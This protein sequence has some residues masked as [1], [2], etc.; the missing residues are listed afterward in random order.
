M[1]TRNQSSV[2]KVHTF[3]AIN[4]LLLMGAIEQCQPC[5]GQFISSTF[6]VPKPNGKM[7]FILNLKNLNKFVD[8]KHFKIEDFR[9]ALKL[10]TKDCFMAKLDLKDAY[11]FVK[12]HPN[13]K[14]YLRFQWEGT[15]YQFCVLPFGLSTS[16]FVFTKIMKPVAKL[17]RTVGFL[18]TVYLDDWFI[19]APSYELCL[20]N[21]YKTKQLLRYLGF[22][23][24]DEKSIVIPSNSCI[25][26]GY[27]IDSKNL[28]V[29][30]PPDKVCRTKREIERFMSISRCKIREFARFVGLLV[31]AC[32]AIEYGWLYTK[33]FERIKYLNL[34]HNIN[35][36]D[37]YMSIPISIESDLKWWK[38]AISTSVNKIKHD[39]YDLE[40]FSDASTTGWG[41]ACAEERASGAW[42]EQ[43]RARHI[44][45]LEILAAFF[46]LKVFTK[47]L[48]NCQIL[49]RIDNTTAISYINRMGGIQYPHLTEVTK[50]LWQWCEKRNLYVYA[51]YIR[52]V[53][54]SEA[55][56]ES[57]RV[58]PDIEWELSS[59][60]FQKIVTKF[61]H[62][63]I[64]LFASRLN[65]K[66]DKYISWHRD[67]EAFAVNAFTVDWT[68]FY[69]YSFPPFSIILKALRKII[70][71]DAKGIMVVPMWPTQPWYP[72]FKSLVCSEMIIFKPN[73]NVI[74]CS[75][76]STRKMHS[77]ITLVAAVLSSQRSSG[78][79]LPK[80]R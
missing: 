9:T 10:V 55:D 27:N 45:Y 25:F 21:I 57:R 60:T 3:Q 40:I 34:N 22:I 38:Q 54:N 11:F 62:P 71:D 72:V 77:R 58:H 6:L 79:K 24:N 59:G 47:D 69:F 19:T 8:T 39:S 31:S 13:F 68:P 35:N 12:I 15:L 5:E 44:N 67:P 36:Y 52:S 65:K 4:E 51:S 1:P 28:Q 64:D 46:G 70:T 76:S 41:V 32:P 43:E 53:D 75:N 78:D 63:D 48:R 42:S 26:L 50:A 30:L 20:E 17:L 66:C 16:P 73:Q 7:R 74:Q 33:L 18:S 2:E 37:K 61:G 29:S 80:L 23:I 49:L 14:K 56:F